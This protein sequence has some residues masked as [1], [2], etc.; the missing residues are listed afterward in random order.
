MSEP[1]PTPLETAPAATA[2][3]ARFALLLRLARRN[4]VRNRRRSLVVLA[5]IGVGLW[6]MLFY[7]AFSRGWEND[8]VH[9]AVSTL[10]GHLQIHAPGYRDDPS[11]EHS[12]APPSDDLRRLLAAPAVAAWAGRVRVTAVVMSA[13]D[14]AGVTLVGIDPQ[15]ERGLSFLDGAVRQGRNLESP[16]D[17]GVV[18]G[19][20]LARRLGLQV[21]QRLVIMTQAADGSVADRGFQVVGLFHGERQSTELGYVFVGRSHLAGIL[22]L[23]DRLSEIAVLLRDRDRLAATVQAMRA[24]APDLDVQPWTVLEPLS[25][26]IL[27]LARSWIWLVY[28]VMYVAMSFGLVNTL[29]MAVLE[30]TRELGLLQALGMRS[31]LILGQV[32]LESV[33]LLVA[34]MAAGGVLLAATLLVTR[35]GLDVSGLAAGAEMWGMSKVIHPALTWTDVASAVA[36]IGVLGLLASL[37]PAVRAAR[38]VP[39]EAITRG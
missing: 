8:V 9:Q 38:R 35:H 1:D 4:V 26:A 19:E 28:L 7:A 16:A 24:A 6:A 18:L 29:L 3:W 12:M 21:G 5:A 30:R 10:T 32:I 11:V 31:R 37:Y 14:T 20:E 25:Q 17:R 33:L 2:G 27:G 36:V 22:G 39:V 23:G 34:G 15:A 13:D